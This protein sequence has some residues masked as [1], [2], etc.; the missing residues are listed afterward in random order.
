MIDRD[1]EN[2]KMRSMDVDMSS[3]AIAQRIRDASE[4]NAL[5]LSLAKA[6]PCRSPYGPPKIDAPEEANQLL[7]SEPT[8]EE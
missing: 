3:E 7:R 4:L 5:G 2:C 6:K 8:A 1:R